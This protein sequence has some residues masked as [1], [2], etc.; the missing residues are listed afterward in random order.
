MATPKAAPVAGDDVGAVVVDCG[1]WLIRMG[2]AGD[3]APKALLSP[4]VGVAASP[5]PRVAGDRLLLAPTAFPDVAPVFELNAAGRASVVDWDAMQAVWMAGAA[6]TGVDLAAA[7]FMIVEPTRAWDDAHR[8]KAFERAFEGCGVPAAYL[9]R[10]SAMTAFAAA[11]TTACV[12]DVG[13]QGAVA[14]PVVDGYALRKTTIASAVGGHSLSQG[15][16]SFADHQLRPQGG[17][18]PDACV[19]IGS[20]ASC[21]R[22]LHEVRRRRKPHAPATT[23]DRGG[24]APARRF[25]VDDLTRVA[26]QNSFSDGHRAFYRL[27]LLHDVKASTLRVSPDAPASA[28]PA[29]AAN[30]GGGDVAM[31]NA[32][33]R[34]GGGAGNGDANESSADGADEENTAVAASKAERDAKD[35]DREKE[36]EREIEKCRERE[37]FPSLST[38]YELPDG[39]V[40][41]VSR[42][43]GDGAHLAD[44]LFDNGR[45]DGLSR[46][47]VSNMVFDAISAC[48][49]DMRRELFG[50]IVLSGGCSL[51]P[52]TVERFTRELAILTP[53]LF[54][55]KI[56]AAQTALE[57]TGGP[58]IGGSIVSSLGTFQ[59][60]WVSRQEYDELGSA[61]ALRKCP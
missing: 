24:A 1:S 22:S 45:H 18:R 58:W 36:R 12:I 7:P 28:A 9:G 42:R 4:S 60:A 41:D 33:A 43:A 55:M 2:S 21:I 17:E 39:N 15:L 46:R 53:Q 51:I 16:Y 14:V 11:R 54:K 61:G 8:S 3:D 20:P 25:D 47:A 29:A 48:D 56:I 6:Q 35:A 57:R 31:A 27:Q 19:P 34:S 32:D 52:G 5:G 13:H 49:V 26:P 50:G 44:A 37:R 30:G 59:Q 23:D 10:G 40:I 38:T